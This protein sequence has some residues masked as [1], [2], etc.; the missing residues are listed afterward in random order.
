MDPVLDDNL[1]LAEEQ[2]DY[3]EVTNYN[4]IPLIK[5][6]NVVYDKSIN[7]RDFIRFGCQNKFFDCRAFRLL[8]RLIFIILC[9]LTVLFILIV[10][11]FCRKVLRRKLN[12]EMNVRVEEAVKKYLVVEKA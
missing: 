4:V 5:I 7:I 6:N 8:R 9:A 1:L 11:F 12:N 2:E 10:I 3:F